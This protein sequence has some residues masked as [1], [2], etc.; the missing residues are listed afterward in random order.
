MTD[1][2]EQTRDHRRQK[3]RARCIREAEWTAIRIGRSSNCVTATLYGQPLEAHSP[4]CIGN[5]V[6]DACLCECHDARGAPVSA[7]PSTV[8]GPGTPSVGPS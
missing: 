1:T 6:P 3:I 7:G 4:S 8:S 5:R 2:R